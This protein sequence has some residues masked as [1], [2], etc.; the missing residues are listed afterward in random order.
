MIVNFEYYDVDGGGFM[1]REVR[2]SLSS[3]CLIT[4]DHVIISADVC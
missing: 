4:R 3:L 1:D 2:C